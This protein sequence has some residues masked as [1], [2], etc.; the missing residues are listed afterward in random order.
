[1][2]E[3]RALLSRQNAVRVACVRGPACAAIQTVTLSVPDM[4]CSACPI[5]FKQ[6]LARVSGVYKASK[7]VERAWRS[8]MG[9]TSIELPIE[10]SRDAGCQSTWK[11]SPSLKLSGT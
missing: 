3:E 8:T 10:A 5:T 7:R 1:M 4:I 6:S 9:M 11:A 2:N